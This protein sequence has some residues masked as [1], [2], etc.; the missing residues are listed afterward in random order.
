MKRLAIYFS[1]VLFAIFSMALLRHQSL[2]NGYCKICKTLFL[3]VS[4]PEDFF[5]P[6]VIRKFPDRSNLGVAAFSF[7][8]KYQGS[9]FIQIKTDRV[10]YNEKIKFELICNSNNKTLREIGEFYERTQT[11]RGN[12]FLLKRF[13]SPEDLPLHKSSRCFLE[14]FSPMQIEG[15]IMVMKASD[16]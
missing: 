16:F 3:L 2:K 6:L 1:L 9:H 12:G 4:K 15:E 10:F 14:I 11:S 5:D 7:S 13:E 8:P